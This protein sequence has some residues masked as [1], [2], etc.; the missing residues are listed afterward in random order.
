MK[1]F[2]GLAALLA[3]VSTTAMAADYT[4]GDIHKNDYKWFQFNVMRSQGNKIPFG[5]QDDN[6]LEMEFGGRSGI[7]DLYGYVDLFDFDDNSGSDRNT[8]FNDNFFIKVN[9]RF[10]LDAMTKKDL[11]VGP[12]Q[13][14]YVSTLL[15]AGDS[16]LWTHF[17]GIGTDV[18]VPWFGKMGLNVYARH[19]K[20][21][22]GSEREG[23]WDGFR[24]STN[25][26]K[27]FYF[28]DNGSFIAYQ[29]Y[30]DY[31]FG[32]ETDYKEGSGNKAEGRSSHSLQWF[33]G[34]YWHS[35]RY[36]VGYGLKIYDDFTGVKD[37]ENFGGY[38]NQETSGVGHYFAVTYKF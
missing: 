8:P 22:Y 13:E 2:L 19:I 30:V 14:W 15:E 32:M 36:S 26:F 16:A 3:A 7:V 29:G 21:D 4:D 9:P 18:Q 20:E 33:N 34:I 11:S 10:S 37:G 35:D 38:E 12:F 23:D 1:K 25:W 27:P 6:Y 5:N 28:L 31:D 17:I 24:V